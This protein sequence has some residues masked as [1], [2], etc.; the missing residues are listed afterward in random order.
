MGFCATAIDYGILNALANIFGWP[1]I[2]ANVVSSSIS[3]YFSYTLNKKVVFRRKGHSEGKTLL[4][5]AFTVII[6]ILVIQTSVLFVLGHGLVEDALA[7]W[8]IDGAWGQLLAT[9]LAKAIA[10]LCT[11]AWNFLTQRQFVFESYEDS[12]N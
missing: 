9:N 5:Y 12:K 11:F 1:L 8:G 2:L 10:G 7:V 6:A 4:L 3:S